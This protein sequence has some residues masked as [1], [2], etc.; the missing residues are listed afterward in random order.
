M[1]NLV[2]LL[3]VILFINISGCSTSIERSPADNGN[4]LFRSAFTFSSIDKNGKKSYVEEVKNDLSQ[5]TINKKLNRKVDIVPSKSL[6]KDAAFYVELDID[7]KTSELIYRIFHSP[8]AF[9]DSAASYSMLAFVQKLMLA[10]EFDTGYAPFEVYHNAKM[11]DPIALDIFYKYRLQ[12]PGYLS[13]DTAKAFESAPYKESLK[14]LDKNRNELSDAIKELKTKRSKENDKRKIGLDAL[15]KAGEDKQ[16]RTLIAKGD[17]EGAAKLLK[18]YLP[19]EDMAP[20]EK[21]FWETY[22]EVLVNPVPLEQRVL[23]YRGLGEDY[24]HSAVIK[25]KELPQKEAIKEGKAFVMSSVMVKNQGSWNRRLR[26]LEAM[27]TKFIATNNGSD[28]FAQAA[29]ISVMFLNHSADP[30]GSPFLSFTPNIDVAHGFGYDRLSSY[31][32]DPRLL[33]FNY[34]STF[35]TEFEYLIPLTTFPDEIVGIADTG[36]QEFPGGITDKKKYL[37]ER[38]YKVVANEYGEAKAESIVKKIKKNTYHFFRGEFPQMED[39]K[40]PSPGA[41]NLAFYKKFLT[42]DEPKPVLSPKGE[43]GCKDLIQL[44]WVAN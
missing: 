22:L 29:R 20:F 18:K 19:W 31:L 28:E 43:L 15:D 24:I 16:F 34:A 36:L 5:Y 30:K 32:V 26:S 42:K 11:G 21:Q 38:L 35:E 44:F 33:N 7:Q 13:E 6:P 1:K 2:Q 17:R 23:I 12:D 4:D 27:N 9:K 10:D 39:V 14:D 25:G 8:T 3:W 41:G 40:I 37:N